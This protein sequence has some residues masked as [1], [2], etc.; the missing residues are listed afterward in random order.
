MGRG[1][2]RDGR[3]A[4]LSRF[5]VL[6]HIVSAPLSPV[7]CVCTYCTNDYHF[8]GAPLVPVDSQ[9]LLR[10]FLQRTPQDFESNSS[11]ASKINFRYV[12]SRIFVDAPLFSFHAPLSDTESSVSSASL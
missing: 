3:D 5:R 8:P 1:G 4:L 11:P 12:I 2:A 10:P 7:I 6:L 9:S